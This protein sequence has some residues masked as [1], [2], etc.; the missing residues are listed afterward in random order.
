MSKASQNVFVELTP[1]QIV[2]LQTVVF[3]RVG[4]P[5]FTNGSARHFYSRKPF[6]KLHSR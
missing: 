6:L 3:K 2:F 1:D 5:A 4:G